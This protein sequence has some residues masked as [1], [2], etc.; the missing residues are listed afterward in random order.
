MA[1]QPLTNALTIDVEDYFQVS[2]FAPHIARSSWDTRECRVERNVGRIL[3]MLA[4][5]QTKATFFTLGWVAQRY[6]GLVRQIVDAGHELASHGYGH[7]RASDLSEQAFFDD[8]QSAKSILEDI[9]GVEVQGYRAPSFSIGEGNLWAFDSLLRAGYS[10]SSSVYP[11]K[12]DHY[13]MPDSPRHVYQ[14]RPGLVEVPITTLRFFNRNFPSS[15]GG[16]FRLLPYALS[17]WMLN[18]VNTVDQQAGVFYFHPWE[19]DS[20]QPRVDGISSKTRFRHYVNIDRMERRL[21]QLLRDFRWGR[22][23]QIFLGAAQQKPR[24]ALAPATA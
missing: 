6:P 1:A 22:M 16:Y 3:E 10:Y 2:A 12:H 23:D 18:R 7:E 4:E 8:I 14:V 19:I 13:G 9:G 15:G 11:I 21:K 5:R 20:D 17:R 24:V